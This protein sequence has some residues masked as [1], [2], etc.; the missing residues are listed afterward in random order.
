MGFIIIY[1]PVAAGALFWIKIPIS[2]LVHVAL[3]VRSCSF[4][5][6]RVRQE[7]H[8]PTDKVAKQMSPLPPL[9]PSLS[10]SH[11]RRRAR[12]RTVSLALS[13]SLLRRLFGWSSLRFESKFVL[14]LVG[15]W[16]GC[17]ASGKESGFCCC[18]LELHRITRLS[19]REGRRR[20]KTAGRCGRIS[21]K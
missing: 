8:P 19:E 14:D 11:C 4:A 13:L 17:R 20:T 10:H 18:L 15:V 21:S 16:I 3:L 6:V 2:T 12:S 7:Q 5:F 9:V 1:I